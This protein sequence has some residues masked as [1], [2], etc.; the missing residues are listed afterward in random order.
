M[1]ADPQRNEFV[2]VRAEEARE[3]EEW[4]TE[5]AVEQELHKIVATFKPHESSQDALALRVTSAEKRAAA[6]RRREEAAAEVAEKKRRREA[7]VHQRLENKFRR[8]FARRRDI[9]TVQMMKGW[10]PGVS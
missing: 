6:A 3:M 1:Q 8:N 2:R 4:G 10:Q 5:E 9:T 7:S